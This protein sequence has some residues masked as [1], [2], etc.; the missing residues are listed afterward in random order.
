MMIYSDEVGIKERSL[1]C[2][3]VI[4]LSGDN[5]LKPP[6]AQKGYYLAESMSFLTEYI[7]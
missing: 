3:K 2:A 1:F 6:H 4:S 7:V 5:S